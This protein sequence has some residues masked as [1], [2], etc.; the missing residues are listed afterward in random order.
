MERLTIDA[1]LRSARRRL[2]RLTPAEA[3]EASSQPGAVLIDVR[4]AENRLRQGRLPAALEISLNVL[5]WRL[6][7]DSGSRHPGAPDLDG[8][9]I[10]ICEQG[11][12]SSLAATRLQDLGFARATDVIGGFE[13]WR[14]AGLP[15][16]P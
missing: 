6:D 12:S 7:T 3:D 10:V 5:E 4:T 14:A 2:V 16:E 1:M 9:P 13:A 8:L 15:I 11:Y